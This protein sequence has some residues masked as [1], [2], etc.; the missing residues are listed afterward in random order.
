M[1]ANLNLKPRLL[2]LSESGKLRLKR[3]CITTSYTDV[4]KLLIKG[5][6]VHKWLI[7]ENSGQK[8]RLGLH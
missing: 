8:A 1:D 5:C 3:P 2:H 7:Y 4:R 6:V